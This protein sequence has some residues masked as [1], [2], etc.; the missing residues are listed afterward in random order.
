MNYAGNSIVEKQLKDLIEKIQKGMN[1]KEALETL[2]GMRAFSYID[3]IKLKILDQAPFTIWAS[4]IDCKV[5]FWEGLCEHY[6]HFSKQDVMGNDF[7]TK[8]VAEDEQDAA[9][10]DQEKIIKDGAFYHNF[11]DDHDKYGN[12]IPLITFCGRIEGDRIGEYWN[13]EIGVDR[14]FLSGEEEKLKQIRKDSQNKRKLRDQLLTQINNDWMALRSQNKDNNASFQQIEAVAIKKT[15]LDEFKNRVI[16]INSSMEYNTIIYQGYVTQIDANY[17]KYKKLCGESRTESSLKEIQI[18]YQKDHE[19]ILQSLGKI[20]NEIQKIACD[21]GFTIEFDSAQIE[22]NGLTQKTD[23]IKKFKGLT[24]K[25]REYKRGIDNQF[26]TSCKESDAD[27]QLSKDSKNL[28]NKSVE[29]DQM[30]KFCNVKIQEVNDNKNVSDKENE[31]NKIEK[32]FD[33]IKG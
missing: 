2:K 20:R 1:E 10:L 33:K 30:I 7:V 9:R 32:D 22:D 28:K 23:L 15:K 27:S 13:A 18:K 4:D 12:T 16:K 8:F 25:I 26:I 14:R 3:Q 31:Y 11:A 21:L 19:T 24:E 17:N 6:Y 5:T 29:L